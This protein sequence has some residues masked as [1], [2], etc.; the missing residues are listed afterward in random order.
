MCEGD[1]SSQTKKKLYLMRQYR[2]DK[3]P[4]HRLVVTGDS[5]FCTLRLP[6]DSLIHTVHYDGLDGK[7]VPVEITLTMVKSV[8]PT[9]PNYL[10]VLNNISKETMIGLGLNPIGPSYYDM[11]QKEIFPN[12]GIEIWQVNATNCHLFEL[13]VNF[14]FIHFS[15]LVY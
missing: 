12:L 5:L 2:K 7:K 15:S 13:K 14:I 8:E 1:I 3:L 11:S 4:K 6:E 10:Q 9:D